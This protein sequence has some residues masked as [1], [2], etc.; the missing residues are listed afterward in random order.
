[1]CSGRASGALTCDNAPPKGFLL[2]KKV[3]WQMSG[4]TSKQLSRG[5]VGSHCADQLL[6]RSG[7]ADHS[8]GS[9]GALGR[10]VYCVGVTMDGPG[11]LPAPTAWVAGKGV[12]SCPIR[13]SGSIR[14]K[15]ARHG[16]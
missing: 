5:H 7:G 12:A 8:M 2:N 6:L 13:V 16:D 1:M 10:R 15:E 9:N 11:V 4:K 3:S 14:G